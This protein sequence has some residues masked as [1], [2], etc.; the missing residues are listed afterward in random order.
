[1]PLWKAHEKFSSDVHKEA[2]LKIQLT[3][4]KSVDAVMNSQVVVNQRIHRQ[5]LIKQL[6]SLK[7]LLKQ[8]LAVRGHEEREENLL[9][10]M[11]L[12]SIDCNELNIWMTA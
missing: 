8:G 2:I 4:Q 12:R 3:K 9:Q 5:M 11:K 7:F 6:S 1:M 10:L